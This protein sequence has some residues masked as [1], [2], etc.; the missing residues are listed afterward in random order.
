MVRT[1][2]AKVIQKTIDYIS[3]TCVK[4]EEVEEYIK[5]KPTYLQYK[6]EKETLPTYFDWMV[7]SDRY[8]KKT[9]K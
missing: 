7:I 9:L 2:I 4:R 3:I 1:K 8:L 6:I 5:E